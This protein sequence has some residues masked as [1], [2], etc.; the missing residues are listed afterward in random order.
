METEGSL[1]WVESAGGPLLLLETDLLHYW[2]GNQAPNGE[3]TDYDRACG[4]DDYLGLITVESRQGLVLGGEPMRTAWWSPRSSNFAGGFLVCWVF[5][6]SES[7]VL[8]ALYNLPEESWQE[9]GIEMQITNQ[10]QVLF[11]SAYSG[12]EVM[13]SIDADLPEG[14]Y[15]IETL[16]HMPNDQTSLIVHR[17]VN[18]GSQGNRGI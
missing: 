8:V 13:D 2:R 1:R 12:D 5:A 7:D 4:I 15:R 17:F 10:R 14:F 18:N 16:H 11:D 6:D 3:P 9:T